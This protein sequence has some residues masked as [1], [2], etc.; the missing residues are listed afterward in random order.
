MFFFIQYHVG[1]LT[2]CFQRR[3][4]GHPS[5]TYLC[6]PLTVRAPRPLHSVFRSA[7]RGFRLRN[8]SN[9]TLSGLPCGKGLTRSSLFI[10]CTGHCPASASL[11]L[12]QGSPFCSSEQAILW[13]NFLHFLSTLFLVLVDT[14]SGHE[15]PQGREQWVPF[16][17]LLQPYFV[18]MPNLTSFTSPVTWCV[19]YNLIFFFNPIGC[20]TIVGIAWCCSIFGFNRPTNFHFVWYWAVWQTCNRHFRPSLQMKN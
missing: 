13:T 3:I 2:F 6:N 1:L 10:L 14:P 15:M 19:Q 20:L 17:W 7:T 4:S 8:A 12:T 18:V 16:C 11:P 9:Q 5:T